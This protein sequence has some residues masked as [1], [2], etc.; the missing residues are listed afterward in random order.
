MALKQIRLVCVDTL[1]KYTSSLNFQN[2]KIIFVG[3]FWCFKKPKHFL[4]LKLTV[5]IL[6]FCLKFATTLHGK[7]TY[8]STRE[9]VSVS[10]VQC[11]SKDSQFGSWLLIKRHSICNL[12]VSFWASALTKAHTLQQSWLE[13]SFNKVSSD[14]LGGG[15]WGWNLARACS[16]SD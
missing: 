5:T 2:W 10:L 6:I 15:G 13:S 8:K 12:R 11:T 3:K 16:I 7:S 14:W 1:Q 4:F 9:I